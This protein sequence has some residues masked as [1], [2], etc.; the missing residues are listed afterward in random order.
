[1][2]IVPL[3]SFMFSQVGLTLLQFKSNLKFFHSLR[4]ERIFRSFGLNFCVALDIT[5]PSSNPR[6]EINPGA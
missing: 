6:I 1:M 3:K 2:W 5:S 4:P